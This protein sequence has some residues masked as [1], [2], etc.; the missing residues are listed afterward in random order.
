[1]IRL[2]VC[3]ACYTVYQYR[4]CLKNCPGCATYPVRKRRA[5]A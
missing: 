1:M 4:R 3:K 2:R 5:K